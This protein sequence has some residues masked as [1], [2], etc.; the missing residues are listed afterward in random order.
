MFNNDDQYDP[1]KAIQDTKDE[2]E[3]IKREVHQ[4]YNLPFSYPRNP[5]E[6]IIYGLAFI[7]ESILHMF[8]V[9]YSSRRNYPLTYKPT[10]SSYTRRK[11][12]K[13]TRLYNLPRKRNTRYKRDR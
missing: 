6:P 2:I 13:P 11:R 9:P 12:A 4:K 1:E 10:S 8:G 3:R 5:F 7:M